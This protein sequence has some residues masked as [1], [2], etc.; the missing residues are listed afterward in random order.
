MNFVLR[1]E[2]EL[3]VGNYILHPSPSNRFWA[4]ISGGRIRNYVAQYK[5]FFN[6]VIVGSPTEEGDFYVIPYSVL[7]PALAQEYRTS[8]KT[9]RLR[10][11]V[12]IRNHQLLVHR[13]PAS[14]DVSLYYGNQFVFTSRKPGVQLS[15][16]ENDYAI[17][18]RKS[19]VEQRLKQSVFRKRVAENF[20]NTCCLSGIEEDRLL[21]AS[22]IVPWSERIETRLDPA[23][24]LYFYASYDRLFDQG[25]ISFDNDLRVLVTPCVEQLSLPL[26][27]ELSQLEGQRLSQPMKWQI[28]SE[29]L[30]YHR[31]HIFQI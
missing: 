9:G 21:I 31:A 13:Y 10:W 5:D 2:G 18:N 26:Q 15:P 24:G 25:F 23:N 3:R 1:N 6:I 11:V 4:N 20:G 29:Y 27:E 30:A 22:H 16:D 19:E 8:D 14:I 28:K 12:S 17:E 7:K